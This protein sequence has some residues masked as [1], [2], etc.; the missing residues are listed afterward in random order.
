MRKLQT[1]LAIATGIEELSR[2]GRETAEFRL[3]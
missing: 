3:T 1:R 2:V